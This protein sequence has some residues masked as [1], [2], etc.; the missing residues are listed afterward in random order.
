M[1]H[2]A[3]APNA[4]RH[5]RP[6][7]AVSVL[8]LLAV[9]AVGAVG[10]VYTANFLHWELVV[11]DAYISFRHAVHLVEGDG[12]VFNRGERVEGYS[13]F[14]WTLLVAG[15]AALGAVPAEAA[16]AAGWA[17]G[18]LTLFGVAVT[19]RRVLGLTAGAGLAAAAWLA[20]GVSWTF[21]AASGMESALFAWA[22]LASWALFFDPLAA[23]PQGAFCIAVAAAVAALTRPE[24]LALAVLAGAGLALAS[25]APRRARV[26][27][28][29]LLGGI[30][31]LHLAWRWTYYGVPLP[32]PAYAKVA[33]SLESLGR[34]LGY[35]GRYLWR[36]GAFALVALAACASYRTRARAWLLAGVLGYALFVVLV[37]GDGLYRY[38]LPAHVAPLLALC[39]ACGLD[40]V[41]RWRPA[42]GLAAAAL[43]T[44]A[45]AWPLVRPDF[46]AGR[47]V[48]ELRRVERLWSEVG[49]ALDAHGS[50]DLLVATNV[51]GRLPF[52]ARRDTLD[53][54][55]LTDPVIARTPLARAGSGYAGHERSNPGY[56]L[57]RAPDVIYVSVLQGIEPRSFRSRAGLERFLA[58]GP[59]RGYAPLLRDPAFVERYRPA[60]LRLADGSLANAFVR[61]ERAAAV[62]PR[63]RLLVFAWARE[64]GP[65]APAD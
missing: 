59:L 55:G 40:R 39:A 1:S 26:T 11:D 24:G 30:L 7:A 42:W 15:L 50:P 52:H 27:A 65:I 5:H 22:V 61:L 48:A 57:E 13:N 58:R 63:D 12:L 8:L 29:A 31:A 38:R 35:L 60:F 9:G 46:F 33:P 37:G 34:G 28:L 36:D 10:A 41:W 19:A 3:S 4:P 25:P 56:V 44:A 20:L 6:G 2:A 18:L 47:S 16:V 23:R 51:A 43:A 45:T 21:W 14:L 54:L 17:L 49:R 64:A 32:N 53:L 62:A